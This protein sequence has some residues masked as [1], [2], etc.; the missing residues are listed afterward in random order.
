MIKEII[1]EHLRKYPFMEITDL[2]KLVFQNEF[3]GGHLIK[4]ENIS[5]RRIQE[6][7][8][9][10]EPNKSLPLT[11]DIGNGLVRLNL[12]AL[13]EKIS[14][15]A[16]NLCFIASA[17]EIKG[18]VE[19]FESKISVIAKL[20][21]EGSVPFSEKQFAEYMNDYKNTGYAPVS[22]SEAYRKEYKPAYRII[23]KEYAE[24]LEAVSIIEKT[25]EN[26]RTAVAIDGRCASGKTALAEKLK[27]IF[28][29]E[30]IHMDD[31]FLPFEKRTSERLA[32]PGGNIDYERFE[33]EVLNNL[34]SEKSFS[35][36]IFNCETGKIEK[37][38]EIK[39]SKIIIIEGSYSHHPRFSD[40]YDVKIFLSTDSGA[41]LERIKER[42]G[43]AWLKM[44][45]EK[46]IPMEEKYFSA[47]NIESLAD[48]KLKT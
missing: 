38:R 9:S 17:N 47:F 4:D 19:S 28:H 2:I 39:P 30:I 1:L 7:L 8:K 44:F 36:G 31:F 15:E 22:H 18:S 42:N 3:G 32:E 35:Y 10:I 37:L 45:K 34:S 27:R 13:D 40:N 48:I 23:K 12:A 41:Q 21:K 14:P 25:A 11:E 29:C 20:C 24:I 6:E 5:L 46:W 26:K 16:I 43:E 33:D